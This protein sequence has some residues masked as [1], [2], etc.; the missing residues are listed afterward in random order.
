MWRKVQAVLG[1]LRQ[2][3]LGARSFL[4][5]TDTDASTSTS[6]TLSL[7]HLGLHISCGVCSLVVQFRYFR[8]FEIPE[9]GKDEAVWREVHAVLG[10]LEGRGGWVP[11]C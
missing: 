5:S 3:R 9:N 10:Y 1:Y 4:T 6:N 2:R 11:D 8:F 7:E